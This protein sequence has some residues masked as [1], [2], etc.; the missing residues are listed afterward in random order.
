[1][2]KAG[3]SRPESAALLLAGFLIDVGALAGVDR[4]G[5]LVVGV[6]GLAKV[7]FAALGLVLTSLHSEAPYELT[8]AMPVVAAVG[9]GPSV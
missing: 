8:R 4:R 2:R 6:L 9:T 1:M 5:S 3:G 7:G